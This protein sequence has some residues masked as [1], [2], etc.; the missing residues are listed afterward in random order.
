MATKAELERRLKLMETNFGRVC[1]ETMEWKIKWE[2]KIGCLIRNQH[3]HERQIRRLEAKE[4]L[5]TSINVKVN[6]GIL[7]AMSKKVKSE[8]CCSLFKGRATSDSFARDDEGWWIRKSCDMIA[9]F[10]FCG[11]ELK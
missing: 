6:T 1:I 10:P 2:S 5:R 11:K 9:Y 3:N 4:S 8:Y 7:E